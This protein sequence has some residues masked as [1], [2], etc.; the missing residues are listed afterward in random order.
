MAEGGRVALGTLIGALGSFAG[1][2]LTDWLRNRRKDRLDAARKKLL[3]IMLEDRRFQW[4]NLSTLMRV[5]GADE[6][7][8]LRLLLEIDAR[9]SQNAGSE[10]WGLISRN[11]LPTS[12]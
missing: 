11:P 5:I 10:E 12:E 7:T 9:G 2:W 8:T 6:P 3:R 1:T 4:R